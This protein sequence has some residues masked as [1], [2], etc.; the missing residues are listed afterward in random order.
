MAR[1]GFVAVAAMLLAGVFLFAV[2]L[3]LPFL[4]QA[5]EPSQI[6]AAGKGSPALSDAHLEWETSGKPGT[7]AVFRDAAGQLGLEPGPAS[8]DT[9][10]PSLNL[11]GG[12]DPFLEQIFADWQPAIDHPRPPVVAALVSR[13][14]RAE[15]NGFLGNSRNPGVRAVL[16]TLDVEH[17]ERF[18]PARATAGQ[19]LEATIYLTALL[20]QGNHFSPALGS[21]IRQLA[22][23][24]ARENK[25][26]ELE[27]IYLD[28]FALGVRM[29][30]QPLTDLAGHFTSPREVRRAAHIMQVLEEEW[31]IYVSAAL[32]TGQP[33]RLATFLVENGKDGLSDLKVAMAHGHGAV[34]LLAERGQRIHAP[35]WRPD[36]AQWPT[37]LSGAGLNAPQAAAGAKYLLAFGGF[38]LAFSGLNLILQERGRGKTL[39]RPVSLTVLQA[40]LIAAAFG[41]TFFVFNEPFIAEAGQKSEFRLQLPISLASVGETPLS[42]GFTLPMDQITLIAL[43]LFFIVQLIIY[44]ICWVKI[45]E[46]RR[47]PVAS[48]LKLR[49]LENEEN[50]FDAGLYVGLGG[51]VVALILLA[52]GALE[53]AALM[54][55]YASTLFGIIFVALFKIC[56][57]RPYRRRLIVE[58]QVHSA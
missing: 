13:R 19:P 48:Q 33:E 56:H 10:D 42:E 6:E 26:G 49:L 14:A 11:W 22:E 32:W 8:G 35:G 51:T 29:Q 3:S 50:L 21:R 37:I 17:A 36:T 45:F 12:P 57:L 24:A 16:A 53:E 30:W 28:L 34:R 41:L 47:Q 2:A 54:A 31:P 4:S 27:A 46:I 52:L 55:A 39:G 15:L 40:G 38:F 23:N 58:S 7:A 20:F 44:V 9:A 18:M 5:I 25:L 43:A 1:G